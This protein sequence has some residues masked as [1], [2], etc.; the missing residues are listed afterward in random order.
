[1]PTTMNLSGGLLTIDKYKT[2]EDSSLMPEDQW[3]KYYSS[4]VTVN[5]KVPPVGG[6]TEWNFKGQIIRMSMDPRTTISQLKE[7]I[8]TYLG[9]M[10]PKKIRLRTYNR[11]ALKE[12]HSLAHY[13]I[14]DNT[15]LEL[16]VKERGGRKK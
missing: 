10:P 13:N 14:L 7:A 5:V 4:N 3:L 1:M 16:S 12:K 6:D 15:M 9:S 2:D 11:S 8:S